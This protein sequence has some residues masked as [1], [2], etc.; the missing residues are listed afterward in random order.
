MKL[1]N[2]GGWSFYS[3]S[4]QGLA[5]LFSLDIRRRVN[6]KR[7]CNIAVTGEAGV[8][9]S[10]F[11]TDIARIL[12]PRFTVREVVSEYSEYMDCLMDLPLGWPM[13][14]DEPQYAIGNREWYKEV[15]QALVNTIESQRFMVHPLIIAIIN[16]SL[17][18]KTIRTYLIQ[19]HVVVYNRGEAYVYRLSPSPH[20][21]KVYSTMM[22]R[23]KY[24]Q[25]D[26]HLCDRDSCLGCKKMVDCQ[27]FRAQYER[28]KI[29]RQMAR[30][31]QQR[32]MAMKTETKR[33]T[34][35]EIAAVAYENRSGFTRED[36][37]IDINA[38]HI[39]LL[40]KARAQI[41]HNRAYKLRTLLV[42]RW[43]EAFKM[44]D[45]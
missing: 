28:K 16:N 15:N 42:R 2:I 23:V 26:N 10:Y 7:A 33:M 12:E 20:E 22:C 38:L 31:G 32:D 5:P 21:D 27:I 13:V 30:Y 18:D 35:E 9:K 40:D 44:P 36:G 25:W 41:G 24:P 1:I 45:N 19:Y 17:L 34:L 8:G 37:T 39:T 11:A 43:P 14:F 4:T 6:Q 29:E 3:D